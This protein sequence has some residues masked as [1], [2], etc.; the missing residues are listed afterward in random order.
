MT[1]EE[2]FNKILDW[3]IEAGESFTDYFMHDRVDD[4][5]WAMFLIGKGYE[6]RGKAILK[7]VHEHELVGEP[8][9]LDQEFLYNIHEYPKFEESLNWKGLPSYD[10]LY[11]ENQDWSRKKYEKDSALWAEFLSTHP[12]YLEKVKE[13]FKDSEDDAE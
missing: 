9:C 3:E 8:C 1:T 6:E 2:I 11:D 7:A 13:F 12:V 10:V 4:K 5:D